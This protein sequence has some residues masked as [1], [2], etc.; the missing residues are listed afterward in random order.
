MP[1]SNRVYNTFILVFGLPTPGVLDAML[2]VASSPI[3]SILR[4]LCVEG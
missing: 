2:G 3:V 4:L 1:Y